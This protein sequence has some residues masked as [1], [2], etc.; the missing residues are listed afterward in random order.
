MDHRDALILAGGLSRRF[1]RDKTQLTLHGQPVLARLIATVRAAGFAPTLLAPDAPRF[2]L[3]N[4]P[5]LEDA[6]PAEGPLMALDGAF[7]RLSGERFLVVACDMPFVTPDACRALWETAPRAAIVHFE[8]S[9]LPGVYAGR[10]RPLI[11]KCLGAGRRDLRAILAH[12]IAPPPHIIPTA[13]RQQ[14]DPADRALIN[15]N[16]P[17]DWEGAQGGLCV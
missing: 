8:G 9:H 12:P 7:R 3:F 4:V 14:C 11:T 13:I 5:I 10:L 16:I 15:I 17:G 1:G 2:R 6:Q